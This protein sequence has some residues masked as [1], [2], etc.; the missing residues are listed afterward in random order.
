[1]STIVLGVATGAIYGLVAVGIVLVYKASRVLNFAQAEFGTFALY[2]TWFLADRREVMPWGAAALVAVAAMTMLGVVFER[3]IVRPMGDA[4]KLS[5]SVATIGVLFLLFGIEILVWSTSPQLVSQPIGGTGIEVF[6]FFLS[7]MHLLALAILAVLGV[8]L[9]LTVSRT[10]FGLGLLAVAEDPETARL[11]G[12]PY[13]RV[14]AF[15]WGAAGAL[16]AIAGL[17]IGP[18]Q[19]VFGPLS[20]T[21]SAFVRGLA[22]ALLG[23]L[24]SLPGAFV[25]GIAV[26]VI[27]AQLVTN[28]GSVL[29]IGSFGVLVV[30]LL[31]LLLRPRGLFGRAT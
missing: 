2:L 16:G 11:M 17:L 12:V 13:H 19:G 18:L 30:I 23:G 25:G 20:V 29:G 22:A 31:V 21:T 26:G 10:R 5:L 14:S 6:G 1:M 9:G 24:T 27:E 4:P 7:P 15:T 8:G 3:F 28:F